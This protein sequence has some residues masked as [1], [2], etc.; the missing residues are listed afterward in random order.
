MELHKSAQRIA[1]VNEARLLV[2]NEAR[3]PNGFV[4]FMDALV[5]NDI[6]NEDW[7]PNKSSAG[8]CWCDSRE[9]QK[10]TTSAASKYLNSHSIWARQILLSA[11]SHT[12]RLGLKIVKLSPVPH[13]NWFKNSCC[14]SVVF[15]IPPAKKTNSLGG[16]MLNG[17]Y[18]SGLVSMRI[19]NFLV[20]CI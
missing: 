9:N 14:Q 3:F 20:M 12:R 18:S 13:A 8:F 6:V 1:N 15:E 10:I 19:I 7:T 2:L 16:G 17:K 11:L 4:K 5:A